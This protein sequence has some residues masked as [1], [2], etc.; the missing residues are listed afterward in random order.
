VAFQ[1]HEAAAK[2]T[3]QANRDKRGANASILHG[4]ILRE[5]NKSYEPALE[6]FQCRSN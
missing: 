4:Y 1:Q 2:Q 5:N 3:G 6:G